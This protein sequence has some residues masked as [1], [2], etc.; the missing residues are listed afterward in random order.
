MGLEKYSD[1]QLRKTSKILLTISMIA[2]AITIITL[3]IGIYQ[4]NKDNDKTLLFLVPT[5]FGP[6]TIFASVFTTI[7]GSEIKKRGKVD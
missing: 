7:I 2:L 5:V 3:I 4:N 1:K 6:I